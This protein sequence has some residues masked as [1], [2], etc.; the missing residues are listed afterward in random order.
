MIRKEQPVESGE[1]ADLQQLANTLATV[2]ETLRRIVSDR[3]ADD[4]RQP[5]HDGSNA[6]VEIICHLLDWEEINGERIWKILHEDHPQMESWDDSLWSIE[7]DYLS[8][9]ALEY[10]D[11]FAVQR[12]NLVE[13][14]GDLENDALQRTAE[15]DERGTVTLEW[16]L[17]KA[18]THDEKHIAELTEALS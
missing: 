9:D 13:M 11:Q 16:L 8:R 1:V 12:A 15:L 6:G 10:L 18:I 2:P 17:Q 4:L 7:H 5:G 3:T 14:L